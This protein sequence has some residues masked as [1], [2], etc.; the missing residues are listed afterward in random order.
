MAGI[1]FFIRPATATS[2]SDWMRIPNADIHVRM[3][4]RL[5]RTVLRGGEG[6]D[7]HDEGSES[8][9]YSVRGELNLE[10][11]KKIVSMFRTGQPFIHDPF[12]ERDVKVI[13]SVLEYDSQNGSFLFEFIEDVI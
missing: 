13:F 9:V 6:D 3:T 1:D 2:S 7:L 8:S 10:D 4:R 5:T 12:D 11:Y